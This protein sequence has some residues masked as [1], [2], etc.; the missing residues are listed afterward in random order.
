MYFFL[1]RLWKRSAH[2]SSLLFF[3]KIWF[4]VFCL[5]EPVYKLFF[6][7]IFFKRKNC[8]RHFPSLFKVISVGNI[9]VGGTGKSVFVAF[10]IKQLHNLRGAI[11]LRGYKGRGAWAGNSVLVSNG[12]ASF[13]DVCM[14]GDEAMMF[15]EM[16]TV[17]IVTGRNRAVS[18]KLLEQFS[19]VQDKQIDFVVLD[20][21]YQNYQVNKD[22]EILL[23]DARFPFG[24]NHCLP[25]GNLREKDCSRADVI[26]LTH[27]DEIDKVRLT[28]IK[29]YLRLKFA[30]QVVVSGR[31][32]FAGLFCCKD[33]MFV[34]VKLMAS[35]KFIAVAGI[36]SFSGFVRSIEVAGLS[37]KT[38]FKYPDHY[39]YT[40]SDLAQICNKFVSGGY[41]GVITTRKDWQKIGS[42]FSY[43]LLKRNITF[44]ILDI[45]FEFL[46]YQERLHF[47]KIMCNR[48]GN[49]FVGQDGYINLM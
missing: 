49:C 11:I 24:N 36:G 38:F 2:F 41:C 28:E 25:A 9:S 40:E 48:L 16:L 5:I 3:Q 15:A 46:S 33:K 31:H 43:Y 20:D 37:V 10:L 17:P 1:D 30:S 29:K 42:K 39:K 32:K 14:A 34:D 7:L 35:K 23:L 27:A 47:F 26:V 45:E 44:F 18:C 6:F 22:F 4:I 21:A 8:N 19:A 12:K 13:V